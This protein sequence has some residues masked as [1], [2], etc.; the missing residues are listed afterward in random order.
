[1]FQGLTV[2]SKKS[3]KKSQSKL[4]TKKPSLEST[5]GTDLSE[6][7]C[8]KIETLQIGTSGGSTTQDNSNSFEGI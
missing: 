2:S 4:T 5:R 7:F 3:S 1:M 8:D 6:S